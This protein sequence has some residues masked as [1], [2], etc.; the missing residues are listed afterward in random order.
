MGPAI[1]RASPGGTL[2]SVPVVDEPAVAL[3]SDLCDIVSRLDVIPPSARVRGLYIR[4]VES[5]I[6]KRGK[7]DEYRSYFPGDRFSS[8]PWY[9]IGDYL[10]R[11]ACA[12]AII[13]SPPEVHRGMFDIARGNAMA[14]AG[15]LLGRAMLRLLS[16]DPVR[17]TEQGLAAHRQSTSYSHWEIVHH[18][19]RAIEMRYR[20]EYCWLESLIAGAAHGTFEACGLEPALETKLTDR[21][22]GSTFVRW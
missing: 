1:R 17:V 4:N 6:E 5:Q 2:A 7:L 21:F 14:F 15:S 13:A 19:E 20:D 16:R 9:P 18:G 22:N 8:L 3:V 11:I 10:V 12:G